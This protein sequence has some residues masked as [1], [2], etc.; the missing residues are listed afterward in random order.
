MPSAGKRP[1]I[2]PLWISVLLLGGFAGGPLYSEEP[3]PGRLSAD[4]VPTLTGP[5]FEAVSVQ[6]DGHLALSSVWDGGVEV[7]FY[8]AEG[9]NL[10]FT[11]ADVLVLGRRWLGTDR[12]GYGSAGVG[13][14]WAQ[15]TPFGVGLVE[16]GWN[17]SL[18]GDWSLEPYGRVFVSVPSSS[19]DGVSGPRGQAGVRLAWAWSPRGDVA[20]S[21]KPG[22][23]A[24]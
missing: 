9:S 24:P 1:R 3:R 13:V 22:L 15:G 17:F 2:A 10:T 20:E 7:A 23:G 11:Q 6:L 4:L 19:G 12:G 5:V 14:G 21:L 18:V 8:R 16:V